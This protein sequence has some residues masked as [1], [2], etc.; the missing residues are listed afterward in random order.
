MYNHSSIGKVV[1]TLMNTIVFFYVAEG[2]MRFYFS[3][4]ERNVPS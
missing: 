2:V 3:V 4:D 1:G